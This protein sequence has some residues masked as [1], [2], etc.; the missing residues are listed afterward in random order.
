MMLT[1]YNRK[2]YM[3]GSFTTAEELELK[4]KAPTTTG[5]DWNYLVAPKIDRDLHEKLLA[6]PSSEMLP[7]ASILPLI[8]SGYFWTALQI[9]DQA[10]TTD[11]LSGVKTWLV[12][13]LTEA[14]DTQDGK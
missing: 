4:A 10:E 3:D 5:L 6:F 9:I 1:T 8:A 7:F 14:D 12:Q 11:N 13:A 2:E